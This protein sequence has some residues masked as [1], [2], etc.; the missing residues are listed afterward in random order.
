MEPIINVM[1]LEKGCNQTVTSNLVYNSIC[2]FDCIP[3]NQF[4]FQNG[5]I[6]CIQR[7]DQPTCKDDVIYMISGRSLRRVRRS[8]KQSRRSSVQRRRSM[9]ISRRRRGKVGLEVLKEHGVVGKGKVGGGGAG[10]EDGGEGETKTVATTLEDCTWQ[11]LCSNGGGAGED[12]EDQHVNDD[13]YIPHNPNK[14]KYNETSTV[15]STTPSKAVPT[16]LPPPLTKAG[17]SQYN[18]E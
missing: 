2:V 14:R 10:E 15:S 1:M 5:L 7:K 17:V 4:Y 9:W 12:E 8:W 18:F 3:I 13:I 11:F 6:E 16:L